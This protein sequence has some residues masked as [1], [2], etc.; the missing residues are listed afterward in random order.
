MTLPENSNSLKHLTQAPGS[1]SEANPVKLDTRLK[2][3][4]LIAPF[5]GIACKPSFD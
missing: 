3:P 1:F 5:S 4:Y 2:K